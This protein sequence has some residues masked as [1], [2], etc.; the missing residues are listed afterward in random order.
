[1]KGFRVSN[2][3]KVVAFLKSISPSTATNAEIVS[4]TG[5]KPHQQV[6]QITKRLTDCGTI[7][8]R[9]HGHEWVFWSSVTATGQ[10]VKPIVVQAN[11]SDESHATLNDMTPREFEVFARQ[12]VEKYFGK[13]LPER[14]VPAVRKRFDYVAEDGSVVGDA[15]YYTLVQGNRYPP[16]KMSVIAEHVW[17]LENV[18]A[19]IRFL[20]FG[21]DRRVPEMWLKKYGHLVRSV[22][23]FFLNN[24]GELSQ[25]HTA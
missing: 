3:E 6:F 7:Q 11:S 2:P 18:D 15:K 14:D 1:M 25:L 22:D 19:E 4:R 16:A 20:V 21:N 24:D 13:T 9:Q 8:A 10:P 17:L 23:F 12:A 5:I